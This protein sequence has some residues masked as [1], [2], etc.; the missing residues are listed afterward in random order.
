MKFDSILFIH[1]KCLSPMEQ[2]IQSTTENNQG[3]LYLYECP[4]CHYLIT[5]QIDI[6]LDDTVEIQVVCENCEKFMNIV[7]DYV[8]PQRG[9]LY[10]RCYRCNQAILLHTLTPDLF[11]RPTS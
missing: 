6:L 5:C 4:E 11:S 1:K 3:M 2:K 10:Y 8:A 9:T 7:P